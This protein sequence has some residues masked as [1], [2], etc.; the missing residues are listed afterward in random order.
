MF[1]LMSCILK[2]LELRDKVNNPVIKMFE[3]KLSLIQNTAIVNQVL[4]LI[5]MSDGPRPLKR[6]DLRNR[7]VG[8]HFKG[9]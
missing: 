1:S 5:C 4:F 9:N 6:L 7:I 3:N 8:V 2:C